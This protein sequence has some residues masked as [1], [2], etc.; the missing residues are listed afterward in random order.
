[1]RKREQSIQRLFADCMGCII[2][3][4]QQFASIGQPSLLRYITA[5]T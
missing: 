5:A 1:M 3:H 2:P 4:A